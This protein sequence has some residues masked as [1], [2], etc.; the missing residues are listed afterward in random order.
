[1]SGLR[2]VPHV[3]WTQ[4]GH[5]WDVKSVDWHPTKSLLVSGICIFLLLF[6]GTVLS[7]YWLTVA[8]WFIVLSCL[9]VEKIILLNFGMPSQGRSFRHCQ[10]KTALLKSAMLLFLST[11]DFIKKKSYIFLAITWMLC[12]V[13]SHGHKNT[14]LCVKWNQNGNWVL[15]A[16]K[17]Q[18]IKV[19]CSISSFSRRC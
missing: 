2:I 12:S 19:G 7:S 17:D 14:V 10:S 6:F 18:I 13:C 8:L 15:T 4:A 9:Q 16:S 5:G 1:M 3:T 11:W